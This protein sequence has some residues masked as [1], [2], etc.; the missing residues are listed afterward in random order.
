MPRL[1]RRVKWDTKHIV[2]D[3]GFVTGMVY[4]ERDEVTD[5]ARLPSRAGGELP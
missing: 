3:D 5:E 4:S 1:S 2:A